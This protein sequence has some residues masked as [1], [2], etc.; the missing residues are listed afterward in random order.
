MEKDKTGRFLKSNL[1]TI[2]ALAVSLFTLIMYIQ[3]TALLTRQTDILIEQ[4]KASTWPH[5][6]IGRGVGFQSEGQP[7]EFDINITNQGNGPAIIE[8]VVMR[9]D[10]VEIE[11]WSDLRKQMQIPE[12]IKS[13]PEIEPLR[14]KVIMPGQMIVIISWLQSPDILQYMYPKFLNLEMEICYRSVLN[15]YWT[16]K[17]KS[18]HESKEFDDDI[19]TYKDGCELNAKKYFKE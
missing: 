18:F 4:N 3:Q 16:V 17:R 19:I 5:L 9:L 15:E 14:N 6:Y 1:L 13:S 2:M 10:G 12:H 8:K 7:T 11:S